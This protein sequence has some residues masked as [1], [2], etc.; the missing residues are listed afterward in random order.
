MEYTAKLVK[1]LGGTLFSVI[2][3]YIILDYIFTVLM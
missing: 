2:V 3:L 1:Y